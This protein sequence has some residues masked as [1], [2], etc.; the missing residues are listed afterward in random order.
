MSSIQYPF[1]PKHI[2]LRRYED[3][4]IYDL[5]IDESYVID[6]EAYSVLMFIN[7]MN[8][9]QKIID[10][11]PE[12]KRADVSE[13]LDDFNELKIIDFTSD[14]ISDPSKIST[15]HIELPS[16]NPFKSP[17]LKNIMINITEK[18][19]LRCKHCYIPNKHQTEFPLDKLKKLINTFYELQGIRLILTGGEPFLYSELK[20]LL[21]FLKDIPLQ[22]VLLSNGLLIKDNMELLKLLKDN[23]FEIYVS[24]DGLEDSHNDFRDADCFNETIEGIKTLL[25]NDISVSINTMI[26]DK[27]IKEFDEMYKMIQELGQIKNWSLDI[28]TFDD[29][30]SKDIAS[31]YQPLPKAAGEILRDYGW[32]LI[33]ESVGEGTVNYACGPHLM[34]VDVLGE[35]T[36]CGFF[37]E[38]NI[39]NIFEIGMIQSW[40]RVQE[41]LNWCLEDLQCGN[42]DCDCEFINDCRGGCRYRAYI[43]TGNI[44]GIDNFKCFQFGK[45]H[46]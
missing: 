40:E 25:A 37:T 10:Q 16:N 23:Y 33:F 45:Q 2:V 9:N 28:P 20:E 32:G 22:K 18:C 39:G 7:G 13:A 14:K 30:L 29:S 15:D 5:K 27:N 43:N 42:K 44:Y 8:S 34:A 35:V 11:F 1:I 6:D 12:E 41:K 26:H 31:K 36:K 4:N 24:L 3:I 19:N 46:K 17:Y 38:E 21:V